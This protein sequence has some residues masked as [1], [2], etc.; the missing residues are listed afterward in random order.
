MALGLGLPRGLSAPVGHRVT[1]QVL[2]G[3]QGRPCGS[4]DLSEVT[5]VPWE[6]LEW[7]WR[8]AVLSLALDEA[9]TGLG[10]GPIPVAELG[11]PPPPKAGD[12]RVCANDH[13]VPSPHWCC[14][15]VTC[16]L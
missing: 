11:L 4:L 10:E 2:S 9:K 7:T 5:G 12:L 14:V 8:N 6:E 16:P 15:G 3:F 1:E 13:T